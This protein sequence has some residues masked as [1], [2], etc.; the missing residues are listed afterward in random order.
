MRHFS[1]GGSF[2]FCPAS[3]GPLSASF[4]IISS[5]CSDP[6]L[7]HHTHQYAHRPLGAYDFWRYAGIVRILFS[8]ANALFRVLSCLEP[9]FPAA[10]IRLHRQ[11]V[12]RMDIHEDS[13]LKGAVPYFAQKPIALFRR[14]ACLIWNSLIL[15]AITL[16]VSVTAPRRVPRTGRMSLLI[17]LDSP[18]S[19]VS[20]G[21]APSLFR[22]GKG[23]A[24]PVRPLPYVPL[25]FALFFSV[26]L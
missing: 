17:P 10:S 26:T 21:D 6:L 7:R 18:L 11:Y 15:I 9:Y 22:I 5:L 8:F 12:L 3:P 4:D 13:F 1:A 19:S 23:F 16:I 24:F 14:F 25:V 20:F 2:R